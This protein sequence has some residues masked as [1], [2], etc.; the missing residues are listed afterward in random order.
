MS[1]KR[2]HLLVYLFTNFSKS[3]DL[4]LKLQQ[5]FEDRYTVALT[6]LPDAPSWLISTGARPM[7]LGLDLRGGVHFLMEVDMDGNVIWQYQYESGIGSA[8]I[9]RAQKYSPDYLMNLTL[10]DLNSDGILNI[11]DIV[12]LANL[13]LSGDDSNPA[14]DLNQDGTQNI[15][16]IVSLVN[17]I[18]TS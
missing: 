17:L 18:L 9:A 7:Y 14:G 5:K 16:D 6:L 11:L 8:W 2:S 13:I 15:L 1:Q 3:V 10:G 12:I 4:S